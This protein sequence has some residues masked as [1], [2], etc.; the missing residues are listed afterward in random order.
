M[1]TTVVQI[2]NSRRIRI[3]KTLLQQ[4]QLE[5]SVDLDVQNRQ[6]VIR[7]LTKPRKDWKEAFQHMASRKDDRFFDP[8][9]PGGFPMG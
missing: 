1:R 9:A 5:D 7:S 6:L 4:C 2:R 3:P 8:A